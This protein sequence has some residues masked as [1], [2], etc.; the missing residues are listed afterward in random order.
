MPAREGRLYLAAVT[1]A[2]SRKA[3]GRSMPGRITEKVAIDA[4]EQAVGR[5]DPP[6]DG[7]L[8]F[9]DC[10]GVRRTFRSFQ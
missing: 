9:H 4:M 10:Q 6:D 7:S 5:E 3:V 1:D 8:A 2:F